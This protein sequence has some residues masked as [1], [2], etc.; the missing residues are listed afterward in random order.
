M[1]CTI[2]YHRAA[3]LCWFYSSIKDPDQL[4]VE[5]VCFKGKVFK[6]CPLNGIIHLLSS[7]VP[8]WCEPCHQGEGGASGARTNP[9]RWLGEEGSLCW[10]LVHYQ[11][12]VLFKCWLFLLHIIC[13]S[14]RSPDWGTDTDHVS[15]SLCVNNK[16]EQRHK[17]AEEAIL[18][19]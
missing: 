5:C 1:I 2:K 9:L 14:F 18:V 15:E 10:L 12:R 11:S 7:R 8:R 19:Q 16:R 3:C 6:L 17:R 13:L 4:Q